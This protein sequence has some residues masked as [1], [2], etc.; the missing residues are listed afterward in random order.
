V[1]LHRFEIRYYN[2][3]GTLMRILG[4]ASRRGL[5]LPYVKA[6]PAGDAYRV[7]L[8]LDAPPKQI[9]QMCRDWRVIVDVIEVSHPVAVQE[10]GAEA[11]APFPSAA[12]SL[13]ASRAHTAH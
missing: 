4:T 8:L 6:E 13:E 2:S 5:D 12:V 9:A 11:S 3:Q 10:S 7:T 1:A